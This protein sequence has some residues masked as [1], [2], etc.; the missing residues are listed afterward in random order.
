MISPLFFLLLIFNTQ[1]K[2]EVSQYSIGANFNQ[3][4]S[5]FVKNDDLSVHEGQMLKPYFNF[6]HSENIK[7]NL[8]F[9]GRPIETIKLRVEQGVVHNIK[10][11]QKVFEIDT[12]FLKIEKKY[13]KP[14]G[15]ILSDA[16]KEKHKYQDSILNIKTR[17]ID[18]YLGMPKPKIDDYKILDSVLWYDFKTNLNPEKYGSSLSISV[19]NVCTITDI[20]EYTIE[21]HIRSYLK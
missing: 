4:K 17:L 18:D 14:S 21:V 20:N 16:Y 3:Y 9:I 2:R 5:I 6:K 1:I 12:F 10:F 11:N 13:G 15:T 7:N 8:T 19:T